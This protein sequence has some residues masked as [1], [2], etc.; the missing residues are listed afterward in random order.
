MRSVLALLIAFTAG[1]LAPQS[2]AQ[3]DGIA[4]CTLYTV[5]PD[6]ANLRTIDGFSGVTLNTVTMTSAAGTIT[7]A[8]GLAQG[9]EALFV[10]LKIQG[11]TNRFLATLDPQTG[12]ATSI[13]DLGD[14]FSSI[15][16][17]P[18]GRLFGVTGDGATA[19]ETLFEISP[20]TAATT[21]VSELGIGDDG[22][23]IACDPNSGGLFHASGN[24]V[25]NDPDEG[26]NLSILDIDKLKSKSRKLSGFETREITAMLVV[27][28]GGVIGA[29]IDEHLIFIDRKGVITEGPA[30]DHS[31]ARGLVPVVS[32]GKQ[33]EAKLKIKVR[34]DRPDLSSISLK[35]SNM[36][37]GPQFDAANAIVEVEIGSETSGTIQLDENGLFKNENGTLSM[38]QD[39]RDGT[40]SLQ[41]KVPRA[42]LGGLQKVGFVNEDIQSTFPLCIRFRSGS[43]ASESL[44][45]VNYK[46]K[47]G[48][49]GSAK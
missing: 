22:E 36:E 11:E 10:L 38:K 24:G 47:L 45:L 17:V 1:A 32:L 26:V 44:L 42:E 28:G 31:N 13:G 39:T 7:G 5:S 3:I 23:V 14:R 34:F 25:L 16:F 48:K 4:V 8:V 49:S 2:R 35:L 40:W 6:D 21:L 12:V 15:A 30:L 33:L 27:P 43:I 41:L 19:P 20:L 29:N 18:D 46:A 37:L 9:P